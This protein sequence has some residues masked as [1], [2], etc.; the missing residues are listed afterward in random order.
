MKIKVYFNFCK[1][2]ESDGCFLVGEYLLGFLCEISVETFQEICIYCSMTVCLL[3]S[4]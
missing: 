3:F 1:M 2:N 4:N